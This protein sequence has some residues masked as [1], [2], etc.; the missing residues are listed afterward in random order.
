MSGLCMKESNIP[1]MKEKK[2][3]KGDEYRDLMYA[4]I[5]YASRQ[6]F[7][8]KTCIKQYSTTIVRNLAIRRINQPRHQGCC[9]FHYHYSSCW[10]M[11]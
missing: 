4:R 1:T 10:A 8:A 2:R 5:S 6:H 11:S 7:Q 9:T 3:R